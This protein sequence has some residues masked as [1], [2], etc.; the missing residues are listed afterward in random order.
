MPPTTFDVVC[1]TDAEGL[2][3]WLQ[4][5]VKALLGWDPR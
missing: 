3:V 4:P 5:T 2:L 1:E